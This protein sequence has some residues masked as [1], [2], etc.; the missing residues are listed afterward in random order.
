MWKD[1]VVIITGSSQGIGKRLA[2]DFGHRGSRIVL[3][4]RDLDKL[5]KTYAEL[6]SEGYH[7]SH[8]VGDIS[9]YEDCKRLV[10]HSISKYGQI[11]VLV[12][13]AG[14]CSKANFKDMKPEVFKRI[15]DVNL[16]GSVFMTQAALPYIQKSKGSILFIGSIA[17]IH[18]IGDYTAYCSSKAAIKTL[19]ESL[20]IEMH[21]L[22]IYVGYANLGFTENDPRKTFL[23]K[24][25]DLVPVPSRKEIKQTPVGEVTAM[26]IKMIEQRQ[27]S[28]TFTLVGKMNELVSRIS[29][30]IVY[31]FLLKSY[32]KS[33]F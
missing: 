2:E 32:L 25:G 7:V 31:K 9:D 4:G 33:E 17:G 27:V 15:V 26:L 30:S 24:N 14:I 16:T 18:G 11:D 23:D 10:E 29:P 19:V 20:R 12:N 13:N 6:K 3:N 8:C 1:K 22:G 28:K 21:N 5:S